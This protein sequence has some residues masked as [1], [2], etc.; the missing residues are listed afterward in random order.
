MTSWWWRRDD[1][2]VTTYR[3]RADLPTAVIPA[4]AGTQARAGLLSAHEEARPPS[5][6]AVRHTC[7]KR[8]RALKC[9]GPG[10]FPLARCRS[11]AA[12]GWRHGRGTGMTS[13]WW[14]RDD[15]MVT[16][17]RFRGDLPTAVI[18]AKAGNQV[19]A[20]SLSA[21]E[22][23]RPP[24]AAA[25]RQTCRKRQRALKCMGPGLFPLARCRSQAAPG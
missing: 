15:T 21:R 17:Y 24:P 16:T 19:R 8:Q 9:M 11:Q 18:P 3:F 20:R 4:K 6:S 12:P 5:G 25:V 13:W 1:T 2:M 10:L 23:A 22:E 7:R 14:R